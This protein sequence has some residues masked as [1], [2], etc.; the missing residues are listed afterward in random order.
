MGLPSLLRR[1]ALAADP[2]G[3]RCQLRCDELDVP[4]GNLRVEIDIP[5]TISGRAVLPRVRVLA[6]VLS[7]RRPLVGRPQ[8]ANAVP[9]APIGT[10][11]RASSPCCRLLPP[12]QIDR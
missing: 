5:D 3:D 10:S 9:A 12:A 7:L 8:E 4:R 11:K 2:I 1:F 6:M